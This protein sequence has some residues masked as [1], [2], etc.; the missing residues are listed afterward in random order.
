MKEREENGIPF[1]MRGLN[2]I[3]IYAIESDRADTVI[4]VRRRKANARPKYVEHKII[5]I[6]ANTLKGQLAMRGIS[7]LEQLSTAAGYNP[8]YVS[9]ARSTKRFTSQLIRRCSRVLGVTSKE[10]R[11][12]LSLPWGHGRWAAR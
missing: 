4:S 3:N 11:A 2:A 7:S 9:W 8:A 1:F 6:D 12:I 5:V 10:A